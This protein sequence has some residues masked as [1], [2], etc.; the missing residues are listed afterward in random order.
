MACLTRQVM[1][2]YR[3]I[4][5]ALIA[6][7]AKNQA[8][9]FE[10]FLLR[11]GLLSINKRRLGSFPLIKVWDVAL[12]PFTCLLCGWVSFTVSLRAKSQRI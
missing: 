4:N 8:S 2:T 11:Q 9:C 1:V 12:P 10:F 7:G 6:I 5:K 3:E